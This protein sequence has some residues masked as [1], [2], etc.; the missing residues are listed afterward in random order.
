MLST[1]NPATEN[2][3]KEYPAESLETLFDRIEQSHIAHR[4]WAK[5][6]ISER[7]QLLVK[8]ADILEKDASKLAPQM[9]EEMGKPLAEAQAEIEKCALV[10]RYYAEKAETFLAPETVSG[11]SGEAEILYQ[12][13]GVVLA[14]MPWNYPY[15]QVFR[16]LA[17]ALMAGNGA[18]LKHAESVTGCAL[19]IVD[20]VNRAGFP[21]TLF[22]ALL[23]EVDN[24]EKVIEHPLVHG[25]TLT[26]SERAG[27]TVAAQAGAALKKTVLE[28][29]G[30]DAA[31]ILDDA[32]LERAAEICAESRL[33]NGGQSCIA[34]KRFILS[35]SRMEEF[36]AALKPHFESRVMGDPKDSDTTLGPMAREDLRETLHRQV[37]ESVEAG[38][39]LELG[40]EIPDGP[41]FYYP[42]TLLSG[43]KPGMPAFDEETFGPVGV[44]IGAAD[45]EDA[46]R[47]ANQSNYGLGSTVITPD[48][49]RGRKI[50]VE[51]LQ[52]GS[53]FVNSGVQSDPKLPFGGIK[54]SGYGREL[55]RFGIH[56]FL[57]I[58]TIHVEP[59]E[60]ED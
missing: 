13:L 23:T 29:G 11:D 54:N 39:R 37:T 55:S 6:R 33:R 28:L 40:G 30:S 45:E 7:A 18:V 56:E 49:E 46:V 5:T 15:W 35:E 44:V 38:A 12:P 19:S 10:C 32:D 17:P 50:A 4:T 41:G 48:L 43:V 16:F 25:V 31:V 22:Q 60:S 8:L 47:L 52:A 42:A 34:T 2:V 21:D 20:L 9:T 14:I 36:V 59:L 24:M 27:R 53:C 58:K 26:G 57:N 3:I 51:Q 1:K